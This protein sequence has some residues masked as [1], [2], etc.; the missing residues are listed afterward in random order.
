MAKDRN[1]DPA[2]GNLHLL[3]DDEYF[4][5]LHNNPVPVYD[6]DGNE[7]TGL[8]DDVVDERDKKGGSQ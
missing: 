5:D 1:Y 7:L 4:D 8:Y 6:A 2:E 3:S